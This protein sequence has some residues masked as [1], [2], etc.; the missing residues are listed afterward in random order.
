MQQKTTWMQLSFIGIL[1]FNVSACKKV[2]K[3][4]FENYT[5][6]N[7]SGY[8]IEIQTFYKRIDT[9]GANNYNHF[10][11]DKTMLEQEINVAGE[12]KPTNGQQTPMIYSADSVIIKFSDGKISR[13]NVLTNSN[14]N[15]L[16]TSNYTQEQ[17]ENNRKKLTYTFT[18]ADYNNAQ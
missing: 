14:F 1:L 11:L 9:L 2:E 7:N 15:I 8:A 3:N 12:I 13:F 10:I 16:N 4:Y 6:K 18:Q 17:I 5:F